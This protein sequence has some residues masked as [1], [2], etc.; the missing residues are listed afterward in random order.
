LPGPKGGVIPPQ[1]I[2]SFAGVKIKYTHYISTT[3]FFHLQQFFYFIYFL[4]LNYHTNFPKSCPD[5][6]LV[7]S[8]KHAFVKHVNTLHSTAFQESTVPCEICGKLGQLPYLIQG[9][10]DKLGQFLS[11]DIQATA[12]LRNC[13]RHSLE[14]CSSLV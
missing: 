2:S 1:F 6:G 10:D 9:A 4:R 7:L 8:T 3:Y 12:I 11:R 13:W 14:S 5:C